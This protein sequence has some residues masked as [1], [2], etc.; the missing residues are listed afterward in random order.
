MRQSLVMGNWKLN[1]SKQF[2]AELINSL[3]PTLANI[4]GCQVAIA[5]PAVYLTEAHRALSGSKIALGAQNVDVNHSGAFTGE[6]SAEMLKDVGAQYIIIGHS[7]RRTHH[8]ESNQQIAEK[9]AVLK[10]TGLTPV[11]CI[12]ETAAENAAGQTEQVC[13]AQ[14]DA[15]LHHL[16]V[17]AFENT[18]I[19]YEPVWAIGTGKSATPEQAQR[20]HHFIRQHIGQHD[21]S[22]AK[23]LVIQYGGSVNDQNAAELFAQP[24]IDGALVGGASLQADAFSAIVKAAAAA[25]HNH[26]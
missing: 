24:D 21:N 14:L 17:K 11:L 4:T 18:V 7:E 2:T 6:L 25:S 23:Q 15:I 19:A 3:K 20:V 26:R 16:G 1:G 5:P 10:A 13:A 12:G 22:L 9:F 8:Q